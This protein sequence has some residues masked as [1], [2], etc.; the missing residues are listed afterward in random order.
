M[1]VTPFVYKE[2]H[3]PPSNFVLIDGSSVDS[4]AAEL[5]VH[6]PFDK[7]LSLMPA[8]IKNYPR[9]ELLMKILERNHVPL[10]VPFER[11][12]LKALNF[13][14]LRGH[15]P[16]LF[17]FEQLEE[18]LKFEEMN[19]DAFFKNQLEVALYRS[20]TLS[21]WEVEKALELAE[22]F[23]FESLAAKLLGFMV[24][25]VKKITDPKTV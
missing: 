1:L 20:Y 3:I 23:G 13:F 22:K 5:I 17:D 8:A 9:F 12:I 16:P 19:P 18:L 14:L 6:C 7:Q 2:F 4:E 25:W 15:L 11:H 21:P 10:R 24:R